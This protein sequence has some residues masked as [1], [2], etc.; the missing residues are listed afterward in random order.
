MFITKFFRTNRGT[1]RGADL[2]KFLAQ[3]VAQTASGQVYELDYD[4][5]FYKSVPSFVPNLHDAKPQ[6]A[7]TLKT[8]KSGA[9]DTLNPAA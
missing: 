6:V 7:E 5:R 4:L 3:T 2:L 8:A 9:S 1:N